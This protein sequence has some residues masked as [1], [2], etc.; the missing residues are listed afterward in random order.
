MIPSSLGAEVSGQGAQGYGRELLG[1]V[2]GAGL[3]PS[4]E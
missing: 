4:L 1:S 3:L 2:A